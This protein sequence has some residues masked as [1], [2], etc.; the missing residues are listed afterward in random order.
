[1]YSEQNEW[2]EWTERQKEVR[3][4]RGWDQV[5]RRKVCPHGLWLR[6][7][8]QVRIIHSFIRP[9]R[10]D[11]RTNRTIS[12]YRAPLCEREKKHSTSFLGRHSLKG[13]GLRK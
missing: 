13:A 10:C 11:S 6:F 1:M 4:G 7:R 8:E 12:I 5:P 3:W 9:V 2:E